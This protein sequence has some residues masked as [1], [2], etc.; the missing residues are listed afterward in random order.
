M[1]SAAPEPTNKEDGIGISKESLLLIGILTRSPFSGSHVLQ[2][3]RWADVQRLTVCCRALKDLSSRSGSSNIANVVQ[4]LRELEILKCLD[5]P[6]PLMHKMLQSIRQYPTRYRLVALECDSA[7]GNQDTVDTYTEDSLEAAFQKVLLSRLFEDTDRIPFAS[8]SNG[9]L[10]GMLSGYECADDEVNVEGAYINVNKPG[11]QAQEEDSQ[12]EPPKK[13]RTLD[14]DADACTSCSLGFCQQP[15]TNISRYFFVR[16]KAY[17]G[18][19]LDKFFLLKLRFCFEH[20]DRHGGSGPRDFS[21]QEDSYNDNDNKKH[22][23][24][25]EQC[26]VKDDEFWVKLFYEKNH[27]DFGEIRF[28]GVG[29]RLSSS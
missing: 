7:V 1:S 15:A 5:C 3:L 16:D 25:M 27:Y 20:V 11:D 17:C 14:H 10:Q 22:G 21:I 26:G 9:N 28:V 6:K 24:T 2:Y 19:C 13:K 12:Q 23:V 18:H 29:P 4:W 8:I